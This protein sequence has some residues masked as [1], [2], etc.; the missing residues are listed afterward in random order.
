MLSIKNITK[1]FHG[2]KIIDSIS[3]DIE[4]GSV[5]LLL[6]KSGVGKSTLLRLLV[7][8]EK[9]D[10]GTITFDQKPLNKNAGMVFQHFNL[11]A[12]MDVLTNITFPLEKILH[13]TREEARIIAMSFLKKYELVDKAYSP[14]GSL[15]GGQKQRLALART[16]ALGPAIICLDEPTSALD[17]LLTGTVVETI[18]SLAKEGY[19]V[20]VSSHDTSL[21]RNLDCTIY[22]LDH[23]KIVESGESIDIK[24]Y[25]EKFLQIK[26]FMAGHF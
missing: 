3:L 7:D 11:F 22:L 24:K 4:K 10:S 12:H 13:K 2:K 5:V 18:Q 20:L 1:I 16:L 25:P 17:P 23:G 21:V 6:G 15:S 9:A 8:L 26:A 14:T 19:T